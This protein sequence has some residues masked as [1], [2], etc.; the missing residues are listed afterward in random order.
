MLSGLGA[1]TVFAQLVVNL[2]LLN[3]LPP[4]GSPYLM[5]CLLANACGF[6]FTLGILS[7]AI[8]SMLGD[9]VDVSSPNHPSCCQL[10]VLH[11]NVCFSCCL[12]RAFRCR[13]HSRCCPLQ[14]PDDGRMQEW[15]KYSHA[16]R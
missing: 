14:S 2:R 3:W 7:P 10:S 8:M 4:N 5:P 11:N 15:T 16:N 1:L 13:L 9:V 12:C 6:Y